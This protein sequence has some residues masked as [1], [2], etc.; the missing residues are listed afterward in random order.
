MKDKKKL[1]NWIIGIGVFAI[2]L[3]IAIHILPVQRQ[4]I[5]DAVSRQCGLCFRAGASECDHTGKFDVR[6]DIGAAINTTMCEEWL[7]VEKRH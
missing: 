5:E 6:G 4:A 1:E 7:G 3:L 2:M